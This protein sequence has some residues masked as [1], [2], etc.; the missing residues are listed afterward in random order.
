MNQQP[1]FDRIRKGLIVSCQAL[2]NEPL[3]GAETMA[4]MAKSA[5]VGGAVAIRANGSQD[6]AAIK[7]VTNLPIIGIIKRDYQDSDVYITPTLEEIRQLMEVGVDLIALDA[8]RRP[9]PNGETLESLIAYMKERGQ[10]VMADISTLEEGLYAASLGVDCVS[11]TLSGYTPYSPQQPDPDYALV[12][13][14]AER[15]T[16]PVF[17]EGKIHT[18]SQAAQMLMIGAHAVVVGS[19]ITR[20]QLITERYAAEIRKAMKQWI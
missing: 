10:K 19:A 9:R 17:A 14:A 1:L 4:K 16:I 20:P 15:L 18:P 6:I 7:S 5:A 12:K 11:T 2:E 3:Y 13:E 8:T